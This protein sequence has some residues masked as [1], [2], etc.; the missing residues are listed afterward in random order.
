MMK[1]QMAGLKPPPK[2]A[3]K[4]SYNPDNIRRK[5]P[6]ARKIY[7]TRSQ[8]KIEDDIKKEANDEDDDDDD[9]SS[10]EDDYQPARKRRAHPSRWTFNPNEDILM[11]EDIT[12]AMLDDTISDFVSNKVSSIS[13]TQ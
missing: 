1:E 4:R 10:D 5:K 3:V 12:D 11:P 8:I 9:E 13:Y 7:G 6:K 2:P